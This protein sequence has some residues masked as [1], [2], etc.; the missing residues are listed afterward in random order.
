MKPAQ[1]P[2]VVY[3]DLVR[4]GYD[5]CAVTFAAARRDTGGFLL[6]TVSALS[7][8]PYT[9]EDFFGVPMYWS[10]FSQGEYLSMLTTL[11]FTLLDASPVG[12]GYGP[13]HRGPEERHPLVFAQKG[14]HEAV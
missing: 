11:G 1:D 5:R 8:P 2:G 6:A 3:T 10:H 4:R 14:D 12:H 9:E 7:E 13:A